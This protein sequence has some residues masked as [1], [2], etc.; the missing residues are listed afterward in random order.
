MLQK[1]KCQ[2]QAVSQSTEVKTALHSAQAEGHPFDLLLLDGE[3]HQSDG[4]LVLDELRNQSGSKIP[5]IM[6]LTGVQLNKDI[7]RCRQ[8]SN[9]RYVTK[10]L[11]ESSLF[12]ALSTMLQAESESTDK[13]KQDDHAVQEP[14]L[15]PLSI[16]LAEDNSVNQLLVLRMLEKRGHSI[17]L[18]NN[19]HEAVQRSADQDFDLILMD[20]QMPIMDG[21]AATMLIRQRE[22]PGS[23]QVP[24]IALTAHALSMYRDKCLAAGMND[25]LL[26]PVRPRELMQMIAKWVPHALKPVD[27][28]PTLA[29][30]ATFELTA[31]EEVQVADR[32]A[33]FKRVDHDHT[34]MADLVDA[35]FQDAPRL[36]E[37]MQTAVQEKNE[38]QLHLH[39]HTLK[40]LVGIFAA[41]K[42]FQLALQIERLAKDK[43]LLEAQTLLPEL[44]SE[45]QRLNHV[46]LKWVRPNSLT[47]KTR[48]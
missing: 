4:F 35:Y 5:T 1:W 18:A 45:M 44:H 36:L 43:N 31:E 9:T 41:Q 39:A 17:T 14:Q 13:V 3:L 32:E 23:K 6:M 29:D 22:Q 33:A 47:Q 27:E 21:I 2:V 8:Y 30:G 7:A 28:Q 37:L 42:A 16:L 24:I 11:R 10:P 19:G 48:P 20:M 25:Y 38:T 26:K 34:L 12:E 40:G 46:L 15:Q